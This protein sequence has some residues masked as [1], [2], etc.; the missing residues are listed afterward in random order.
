MK[1]DFTIFFSLFLVTFKLA[2]ADAPKHL[3]NWVVWNIGQGQWVTH[4]MTDE[5]HHFDA[6]GEFGSFQNIRKN[7]FHFCGK[8]PNKLNISHW[9]Y[10]HIFNIPALARSLPDLCW[11]NR[12][13]YG[14]NKKYAQKI[15]Q[16]K[17]PYCKADNT[18]LKAWT[19]LSPRD[20]NSS[21]IVF[22][23][24]DVLITGDSP[25]TQEKIWIQQFKEVFKTKVLI[26]GHHGSRTSTGQELLRNLPNLNISIA[27]ARYIKY[28]HPHLDTLKRLASFKIPVIKTEDWGNI[29]FFQ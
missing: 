23:E 28:K 5:C 9:D 11:Q 6:G 20:T 10:D 14:S 27:S 26:L 22:S 17:I 13:E 19:P 8:K 21:S 29:W 18:S 1:T 24:E 16:L 7:L 4:I 3:N 15:L 2:T 25:I 12:P